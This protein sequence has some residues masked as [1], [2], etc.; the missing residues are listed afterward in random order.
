MRVVFSRPAATAFITTC[1]GR[2]LPIYT[3]VVVYIMWCIDV[4]Q[5]QWASRIMLSKQPGGGT[6]MQCLCQINDGVKYTVLEILPGRTRLVSGY[7]SPKYASQYL[8]PL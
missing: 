7:D 2:P 4:V 1:Q 3:T 6:L 8:P 5:V